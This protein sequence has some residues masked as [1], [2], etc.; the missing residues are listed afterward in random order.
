MPSNRH[1]YVN[2]QTQ[3]V[4]HSATRQDKVPEGFVYAGMSQLSVKSA[5]SY[6]TN[7]VAGYKIINGDTHGSNAS[8][9]E[10]DTPTT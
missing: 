2:R 6:Y 8:K 3:K 7:N 4:V 9:E 5:A 10:A 1:Y